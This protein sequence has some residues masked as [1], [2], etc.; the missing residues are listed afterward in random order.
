MKRNALSLLLVVIVLLTSAPVAWAG[1]M[2][3]S[4]HDHRVAYKW[5]YSGEFVAHK[6]YNWD[7]LAEGATWRYHFSIKEAVNGEYSVGA[8][9]FMT[10]GVDV[11]GQ[12]KATQRNYKHWAGDNLAA[13]GTADYNDTTYY[14]MFLYAE[15]AVWFALST[16]SYETYY[17]GL[18][19]VWTSG[20]RAYE[21]HSLVDTPAVYSFPMEPKPI[22]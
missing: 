12:V 9:H 19:K 2:G 10:E 11:V 1:P 13:V 18:G 7:N 8:I 15:R 17:W 20:L 14:F 3:E 5:N 21:L 22:H 6:G 4:K 16:T